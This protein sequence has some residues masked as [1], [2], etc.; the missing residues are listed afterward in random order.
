MRRVSLRKR[1]RRARP[2]WGIHRAIVALTEKMVRGEGFGTVLAD[3]TRIAAE[4]IGRGAEEY[5]VHIGGP[6]TGYA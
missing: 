5:A 4:R 6:G 1:R 2:D 3:G